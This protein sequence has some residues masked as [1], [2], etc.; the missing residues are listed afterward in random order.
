MILTVTPGPALDLTWH[1]ERLVPGDT[2]RTR[3]GAH[4]AGGKGVNVSRVLAAMGHATEA[5]AP[6]GGETGDRFTRELGE[7]GI[8][9][10]LISV[11]SETR[12]TVTIVDQ[13]S[14][15][16]TVIS[17]EAPTLTPDEW[18]ELTERVESRLANATVLVVS[19]RI[20]ASAPADLLARL[21]RSATANGVSTIVDTSGPSMLEAARAGA[22]I[23]KPNR[24]ELAEATGED[25]ISG[26][27]TALLRLGA[28]TV[29]VSLGEDGL[30]AAVRS[31]PALLHRAALRRPVHGNATGAGD[32]AV[33]ALAAGLEQ[34]RSLD[35]MLRTAAIWAGSAVSM[36]LAGELNETRLGAL[37][38]DLVSANEVIGE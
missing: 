19:G 25:T 33:A 32:A 27:I 26:G 6:V 35:Q 38:S 28:E 12:Q 22:T 21:V 3:P 4:R 17:E 37:E 29:C 5:V 16:A 7:S 10:C 9:A 31:D 15:Q 11:Q 2:L 24:D 8:S 34:G 36:P 14:G 1:V 30:A 20:S 18:I 23:L 13:N